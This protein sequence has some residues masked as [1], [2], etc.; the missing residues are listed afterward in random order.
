MATQTHGEV[1]E[2]GAGAGAE[3]AVTPVAGTSVGG[4]LVDV[5]ASVV[6][7]SLVGA[8]VGVW[9]V[10][11]WVGVWVG[12]RVGRMDRL[13]SADATLLAIAPPPPAHPVSASEAAMS[14]VHDRNLS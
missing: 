5:G 8:C 10:G 7:A 14:R 13:G 2:I 11:A 4:A 6:G 1:D 3:E 9:V 12:L